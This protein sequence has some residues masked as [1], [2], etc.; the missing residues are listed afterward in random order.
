MI[1]ISIQVED[2][3][4]DLTTQENTNFKTP[5][6]DAQHHHSEKRQFEEGTPILQALCT[7]P[8]SSEKK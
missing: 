7:P 3:A 6:L 8:F 5:P 2:A 4:V 1:W